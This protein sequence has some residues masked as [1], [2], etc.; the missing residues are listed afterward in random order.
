MAVMSAKLFLS[1]GVLND[2][3]LF[4]LAYDLAKRLLSKQLPKDKIRKLMNFL[5]YYKRFESPEMFA[6]FERE[7]GILTERNITM[8]IEEFL[9]D[10]AKKEGIEQGEYKKSLAIAREMKNDGIPLNQIAKFTKLS[11]EEIESL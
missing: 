1:R 8:G 7:I 6:K 2:H 9:L 11:I 10:R 4:D 3:Q 5:R